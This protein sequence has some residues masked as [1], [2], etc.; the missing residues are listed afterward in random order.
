VAKAEPDDDGNDLDPPEPPEIRRSATVLR[1][2][3]AVL[4]LIGIGIVGAIGGFERAGVSHEL[5]AVEQHEAVDAGDWEFTVDDAVAGLELRDVQPSDRGNYLIEVD[6]TMKNVADR[7]RA[8]FDRVTINDVDGLVDAKPHRYIMIRDNGLAAYL[9]PDLPER[10][11]FIW[12]VKA[13]SPVP[14]DLTVTLRGQYTKV[15]SWAAIVNSTITYD[16]P[17]AT[18]HATVTNRTGIR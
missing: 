5:P 12:E 9:Q 3:V 14:K 2:V 10:V 18:V 11:A 7:T 6:V 1:M 15:V 13:G 16:D 4:G 8:V 17:A